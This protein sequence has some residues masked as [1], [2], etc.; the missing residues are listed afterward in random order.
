MGKDRFDL[1]ALLGH[2][3]KVGEN[4]WGVILGT[5]KLEAIF[6]PIKEGKEKLSTK[7]LERFKDDQ[8]FP[9]WW[10]MPQVS[11]FELENL[12]ASINKMTPRDERLIWRIY[13]ILKNI[14]IASCIMSFINPKQFAIISPPVENLLNIRG[15]DHVKKY[16]NY[17]SDLELIGDAYGFDRIADVDHALWTLANIINSDQLRNKP[18]YDQFYSDYQ[19]RP[20]I[21][22][23]IA[24]RN[25]LKQIWGE[26]AL[27]LDLARLFF[28]SDPI[29]A[30]LI[31][32]RE[33]EYVIKWLCKENKA[34][35]KYKTVNG[36]YWIYIP[37]LVE[38]LR[39]KKAI[40]PDEEEK[41]K[42]YWELR[43]LLVHGSEVPDETLNEVQGMIDWL[44]EL[45]KT[46]SIRLR[47]SIGYSISRKE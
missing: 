28:E 37:E 29:L 13:D 8:A 21:I 11:N 3:R 6:A 15:K 10:K 35:L 18:P 30:G 7:H 2:F 39:M 36:I 16:V 24:A 20:N 9:T 25:S 26:E 31:A 40:T 43:N 22:K 44:D 23:T 46:H 41:A 34:K 32:S 1:K 19:S 45:S 42:K 14:E 38:N 17:L 12:V 33:F 27:Y 47:T 4:R 5:D